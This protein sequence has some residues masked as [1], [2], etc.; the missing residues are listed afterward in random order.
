M[1]FTLCVYLRFAEVAVE[2]GK[3]KSVLGLEGSYL[4]ADSIGQ[5]MLSHLNEETKHV[6][7]VVI[8]VNDYEKCVLCWYIPQY[9]T[10]YNSFITSYCSKRAW[11]VSWLLVASLP[12]SGN[13]D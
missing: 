13:E 5:N 4:G 10:P 9:L 11:R 3:E 2:S 12:A 7:T 6:F 1:G 8:T